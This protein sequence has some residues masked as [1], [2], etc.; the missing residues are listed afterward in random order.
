[1]LRVTAWQRPTIGCSES[2]GIPR[3][4]GG[5]PADL[6]E[7]VVSAARASRL[8]DWPP[9]QQSQ[10]AGEQA[11]VQRLS[12]S[13]SKL[14]VRAAEY[15]GFR[16]LVSTRLC[17]PPTSVRLPWPPRMPP[18]LLQEHYMSAAAGS[19]AVQAHLSCTVKSMCRFMQRL[20][21][22]QR[23]S[24]WR[25]LLL[26]CFTLWRLQAMLQLRRRGA[27][28]PHLGH[29]RLSGL[30]GGRG[31]EQPLHARAA[32]A[33]GAAAPCLARNKLTVLNPANCAVRIR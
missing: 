1:L 8:D 22:Q 23:G 24:L 5:E 16:A 31:R 30:G 12:A 7:S 29:R 14:Q 17:M 28:C 13:L 4:A 21:R 25:A 26:R 6:P 18:L 3:R 19:R 11:E 27:L 10:P 32:R 33:H 15:T 2:L 9:N 20:H